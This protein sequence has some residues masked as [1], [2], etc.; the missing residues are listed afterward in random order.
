MVGDWLLPFAVCILSH[1]ALLAVALLVKPA[2]SASPV[3]ET[4][5]CFVI[6]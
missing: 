2:W 6:A 5:V 4:C 3:F 1:D